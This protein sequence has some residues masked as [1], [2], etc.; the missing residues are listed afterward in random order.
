MDEDGRISDPELMVLVLVTA[1][2]GSS[3]VN[4]LPPRRMQMIHSAS[5]KGLGCF[6]ESGSRTE[7]GA[8]CQGTDKGKGKHF[9]QFSLKGVVETRSLHSELPRSPENP[10]SQES[11]VFSCNTSPALELTRLFPPGLLRLVTR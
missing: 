7:G 3:L 1:D 10:A 8:G 2:P 4:L 6:I 5:T 11:I 9:V